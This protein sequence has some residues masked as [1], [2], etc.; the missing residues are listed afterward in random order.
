VWRR[1][2]LGRLSMLQVRQLHAAYAATPVLRGV[3]LSLAPGEVVAMLGRNG[4]GRS[5]LVKTLMG[6][7]PGQG[8]VCFKGQSVLGWPPHTLARL[9]LGYVP[10][11]RDIFPGLSVMQNLHLG[12]KPGPGAYRWTAEDLLARFPLLRARQ[13]ISAGVL[14]GG[15]QQMLALGRTLMGHPDCLLIDEATEGLAPLIVDQIASCLQD[16]QR[17]GVAILL[18]DQKLKLAMRLAQ[19]VLVLGRGRVVFESTPAELLRHRDVCRAWLD[20]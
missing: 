4:S 14:S 19:R 13:H 11:S 5:T 18:L 12:E 9:G 2:F 7:L 1:L 3:S 10:E 6:L 15:E 16:L 17:Q 8:E 20:M